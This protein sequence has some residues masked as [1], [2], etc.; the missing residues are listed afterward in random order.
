MYR[1]SVDHVVT[2]SSDDLVLFR[3]SP[4][5]CWMERLTLEN[6]DHGIPPD[7]GAR[8][9]RSPFRPQ[10]AF[11]ATLRANGRQFVQIDWDMDE[12]KRRAATLEAMRTGIDFI[13][14][15][16]LAVGPLAGPANLLM[17]TSGFSELGDYLYLPCD[18]QGDTGGHDIFRL[19]FL[20]DLLHSIQGQLP[21]R[22]LMIRQ[23]ADEL[24]ALDTDDHIH[25]YRAVKR[26]FM[27]A[28]KEFRKHR[29]PD[30]AES[31]HCGRWYDC[32]NEVL[33][34]RMVQRQ[35]PGREPEAEPAPHRA[36]PGRGEVLASAP[37]RVVAG[38]RGAELYDLDSVT[39]RKPAA[40][41]PGLQVVGTL[42]EQARRL[43]E[44]A[45]PAAAEHTGP[46][47]QPLRYI[48]ESS[49]PP[50]MLAGFNPAPARKAP[51][52]S[53][54]TLSSI[55]GAASPAR[56]DADQGWVVAPPPRPASSGPAPHPLDSPGFNISAHIRV[57]GR[58]SPAGV[59]LDTPSYEVESAAV[60]REPPRQTPPP[61]GDRLN[62]SD[63]FDS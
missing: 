11:A 37:R 42:A 43:G 40:A 13:V 38:H 7:R 60:E 56:R 12:R 61:F 20:A 5:A 24:S 2:Y 53:A 54:A 50:E 22:M 26:R 39:P 48:G 58:T 63:A 3:E 27:L 17:R 41:S 29:M 25:Y 51:E 57:A 4:F 18:T 15:G 23:G 46:G 8:P 14:D 55:S 44:G 34:Q 6:P 19:C 31:S 47:L 49:A 21:S 10:V 28:Q 45:I 16:Q 35:Q 30:P 9:P 52:D 62:T 1:Y 36:D 33:R 32:A 59:T